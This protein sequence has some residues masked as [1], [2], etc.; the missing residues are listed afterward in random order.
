MTQTFI[1]HQLILKRKYLYFISASFLQHKTTTKESFMFGKALLTR[2]ENSNQTKASNLFPLYSVQDDDT[3]I[4]ACNYN[5]ACKQS[6]M[7]ED[8]LILQH[9]ESS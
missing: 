3:S 1:V 6:L 5:C 8:K 4:C 2:V 7:S 9:T